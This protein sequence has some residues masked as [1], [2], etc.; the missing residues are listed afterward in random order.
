[1]SGVFEN[2]REILTRM[3]ISYGVRTQQAYA[4]LK[5]I[6]VG[7][8]HNWIKRG[9]LPGDYIVMCA[10]DTGADVRWLVNGDDAKVERKASASH[11]ITGERLLEA[12]QSSGGKV[13]LK[14]LMDA[15]GFT[16]QKQLGEHLGIPSGTMSAWL[17]REHFPGEVVI[18]CALDTGVS[19]Y[20]LATGYGS[21]Y[22]EDFSQ[23][24]DDDE[25]L[26]VHKYYLTNGQLV[27][28]GYWLGDASLFLGNINDQIAV[29]KS[30]DIFC[31]DTSSQT[32]SNGMWLIS[33][34]GVL[35]IYDVIRLPGNKLKLSSESASFEC[36]VSDVI[37][38]GNVNFII[39]KIR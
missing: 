15:Y 2:V 30:G 34:D 16:M 25:T 1:M 8:V 38:K 36:S 27:E 29:D 32:I 12:M 24:R 3:L 33:I 14:R 23:A 21:M 18:A 37:P 35:D 6:P 17:R 26:K 4:E 39:K 13:V 20:W 19:L 31:L 7:T 22:P 10:L 5:K 28:T 11:S 9:K